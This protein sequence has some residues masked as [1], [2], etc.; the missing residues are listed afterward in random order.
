MNE[1]QIGIPKKW[2]NSKGQF[3]STSDVENIRRFYAKSFDE[4]ERKRMPNLKDM[5]R[6]MDM[7]TYRNTVNAGA[8]VAVDSFVMYVGESD[9]PVQMLNFRQKL[10][11]AKKMNTKLFYK[12]KQVTQSEL[13]DVILKDIDKTKKEFIKEN[14]FYYKTYVFLRDDR[15]KNH[16]IFDPTKAPSKSY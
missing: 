3:I 8:D 1:E 13:I 9:V 10:S 6:K 11:A 16:L 5:I 2:R 14:G 7:D 15:A 4:D 12:N